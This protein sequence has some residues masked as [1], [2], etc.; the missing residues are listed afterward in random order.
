MQEAKALAFGAAKAVPVGLCRFQ[1]R[2]RAVD[3]GAHEVLRRLDGAIDM[4][5]GGEVDDGG[6][7]MFRQ[8]RRYQDLIVDRALD[9]TMRGAIHQ[10]FEIGGIA[11]VSQGI[12]RH[13][14]VA[15]RH[16]TMNEVAAD[17]SG[18]AGDQD[19]FHRLCPP[20]WVG[21]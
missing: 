1:Q 13:T 8:E 11:G 19:R 21:D 14:W 16:Q 4:G 17:E 10:A 3:V 7:P 6:R 2:E 15:R 5:F 9:E 12:E 18:A 20:R